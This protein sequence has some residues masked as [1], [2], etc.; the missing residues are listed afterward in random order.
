MRRH[1]RVAHVRS[2]SQFAALRADG[3]R[4]RRRAIQVTWAPPAADAADDLARLPAVAYA[5][6]KPVGTAVVR[7]RLR[8]RLRALVAELAPPPGTYLVVV[9]PAAA[10]LGFDEL[11]ADLA[12]G[13]DDL[14]DAA[15]RNGASR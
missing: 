4:S 1:V 7:N 6:G 10:G 15:V 12:A 5:I 14:A 2:R 9:T 13:L 8:R 3:R 11:R